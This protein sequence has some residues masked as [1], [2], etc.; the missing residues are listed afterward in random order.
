MNE[1]DQIISAG[2]KGEVIDVVHLQKL[3]GSYEKIVLRGAGAFGSELGK[4]LATVDMLQGKLLYWDIRAPELKVLHGIEVAVPYSAD[5]LP[6]TTL[7]INCIPN[8]STAGTEI[9][10]EIEAHGYSNT[11]SGMGLFEAAVCDL[12]VDTGFGSKVCIETTSCNWCSC[13]LMMNL[14]KSSTK[15]SNKHLFDTPELSFQIITFVVT[16]KCTLECMHCGQYIPYF[17]EEMKQHIPFE[18]ISSDIDTF[19]SAIDTVGFVSLIGGEPFTHP[20]LLA[21]IDKILEK[22][23]FGVLGITTNGVCKIGP[24]LLEKLK[25]DRIRVIFSDYTRSLDE[26]QKVLFAKNIQKIREYGIN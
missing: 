1:L 7:V 4:Y 16:H 15:T 22:R 18:Q 11:L 3:L 5:F 24:E 13:D 20:D 8:G 14:L 12:N 9:Q 19:F 25:N 21:I 26:K 6:D 10:N 23:N 17:H 2:R